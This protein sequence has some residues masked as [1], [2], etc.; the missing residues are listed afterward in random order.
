MT[1]RAEHKRAKL[2]WLRA[3]VQAVCLGVFVYLALAAQLKWHSPL[4][5]DLFLRFDPLVW[6]IVSTAGREVAVS[7][8]LALA[9]V[10]VTALF[11]RGELRQVA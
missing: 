1:D 2:P 9:L 10:V 3:G 11:G 6:L 4:P 8:W 5:H 7:G